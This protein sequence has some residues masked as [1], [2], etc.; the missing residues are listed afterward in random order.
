MKVSSFDEVK[1]PRRC[2]KVLNTKKHRYRNKRWSNN[3]RD[4]LGLNGSDGT[5]LDLGFYHNTTD[6]RVAKRQST[7]I[8][9]FF[10]FEVGIRESLLCLQLKLHTGL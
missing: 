1:M 5:N 4:S 7:R 10:N 6:R 2:D 9:R 8:P 3:Q